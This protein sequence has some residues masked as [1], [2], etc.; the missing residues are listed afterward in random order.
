M[1]LWDFRVSVQVVDL[2]KLKEGDFETSQDTAVCYGLLLTARSRRGL[3]L[4]R[5]DGLLALA[6]EDAACV[7]RTTNW[8]PAV[9]ASQFRPSDAM[10]C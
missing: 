9:A 7:F 2:G 6:V 3:G 4:A 1:A 8:L 5:G 10:F